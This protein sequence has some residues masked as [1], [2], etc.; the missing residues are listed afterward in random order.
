[1]NRRG[2]LWVIGLLAFAGL[3]AVFLWSAPQQPA[4]ANISGLPVQAGNFTRADGPRT[5]EFPADHGPHPDFQTEWWYYTGNLSDSNGQ[6]YGYQLTFFRRALTPPDERQERASGWGTDQVYMAHFTLTRVS[7]QRFNAFERLARGAAGLSGAQG[8]PVYRVWLQDWR[9]EQ[10]G[11]GRYHLEAAADDIK[12]EL[13]LRDTKGP[14]LQGDAGYSR[15]GAEAGNASYYIS[16]TRLESQGTLTTGAETVQVSGFSWMDHEFST[17]VLSEGQVGWDWFALQLDD[18]SELMVYNIRQADGSPDAYSSGMFIDATGNTTPL[19]RED[20]QIDVLSTWRS[21]QSGADYPAG[22]RIQV[23]AIALTMEV[24]PLIPDQELN[25]SFTYWEGA[26]RLNGQ[27][28]GAAFN[29]FGY[30]ELTGYAH[31]MQGQF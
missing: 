14:V 17:S 1:M 12:L 26:V 27:R 6:R 29:G 10:T 19:A 16:Q 5:F 13:D 3:A 22:W 31:S 2:W 28:S 23:P 9:V 11:E 4:Q 18:G 25:V 8:E 15:K 21:P 24:Q 7:A 30:V 20:F